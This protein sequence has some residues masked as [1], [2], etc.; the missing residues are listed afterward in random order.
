[1]LFPFSDELFSK[2]RGMTYRSEMAFT[3]GGGTLT[4]SSR[5]NWMLNITYIHAG[6]L[7]RVDTHYLL[8]GNNIA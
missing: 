1:M 2:N 3:G 8:I 4:G 6:A 7:E 5:W